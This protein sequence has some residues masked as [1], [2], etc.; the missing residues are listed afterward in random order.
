MVAPIPIKIAGAINRR[1]MGM[2][3]GTDKKND[4]LGLA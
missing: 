4:W 3:R 2:D 1:K